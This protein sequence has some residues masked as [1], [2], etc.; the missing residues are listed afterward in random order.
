[1]Y[2]GFPK[3]ALE[4]LCCPADGA[5]LHSAF[6]AAFV[7]SGV[8]SCRHCATAYP[9]EE[10][11]LRLFDSSSLDRGN[12]EN[13]AVFEHNSAAEGF[14]WELD[15]ESRVEISSTLGALAPLDGCQLLEYGCGNGRYTVRM[16]PQVQL[17]IATDFSLAALRNVARRADASWN[18]ALVQADCLRPLARPAVFDRILCTL[19]SNLMSKEQRCELFQAAARA[20][21]PDGRFVHSAHH[22][23]LRAWLQRV[24]RSGYYNGHRIYRYLS[25][26]RELADETRK[27]FESV[28]CRPIKVSLP[29]TRRLGLAGAGAL[30]LEKIPLLNNFGE[31]LLVTGCK[32]RPGMS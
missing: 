26:R 31:L 18:I 22:Y 11:I 28:E 14:E 1:M 10:G 32:P 27:A 7:Q 30:R 21:K 20:L 4:L 6:D 17:L 9:I 13:Q 16:A 23:N 12:S 3:S 5:A 25:G 8:V 15:S 2:N 29:F 19:T 24:P